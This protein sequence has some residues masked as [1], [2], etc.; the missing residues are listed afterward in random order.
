V[1]RYLERLLSVLRVWM[2]QLG[3]IKTRRPA[4]GRLR[5]KKV[6]YGNRPSGTIK[7]AHG[8][9]IGLYDSTRPKKC[10]LCISEATR[11][12][13]SVITRQNEV[14]HC[15]ACGYDWS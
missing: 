9:R 5:I 11:N 4:L 12:G 10:P 2:E 3:M 15:V 6:E 14:W 13:N 8:S 1:H 7:K